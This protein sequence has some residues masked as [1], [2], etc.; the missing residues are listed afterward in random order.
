[1]GGLKDLDRLERSQ[2]HEQ[3][4]QCDHQVENYYFNSQAT[5]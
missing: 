5:P 1:M 4:G 2:R 3:T